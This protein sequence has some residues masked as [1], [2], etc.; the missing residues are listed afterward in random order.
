MGKETKEKKGAAAA[1]EKKEKGVKA[2]II[3][4]KLIDDKAVQAALE[5][6]NKEKDDRKKRAA[7]RALCIATYFNRKTRLQ[8]LQRRTED[9]ITKEKLDA[10]KKL[11]ERLIGFETEIKDGI[12]VP[13]DKKIADEERLTSTQLEDET[14]KLNDEMDKKFREADQEYTKAVRELRDSYEGEYRYYLN[15]W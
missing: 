2:E 1:E 8:L 11:L 14:K 3:S 5:E 10:S 13:T 7:K 9:D 6:I 12:L 4:D 15:D